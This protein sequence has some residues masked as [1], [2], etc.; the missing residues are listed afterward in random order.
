VDERFELS[1]PSR[2]TA[3]MV[4]GACVLLVLAGLAAVVR[5]G[6]LAVE[7]PTAPAGPGPGDPP[8]PGD[9]PDGPPDRPD[10]PDQPPVGL[11]VRR[12]LWA[13][14]LAVIAGIGAG[15]LAAGAGGRLVMRLLAVTAGDGAQGRITEADQVVGR[16]SAGGTVE[17]VVFT[18][19]FF[20]TATGAAYLLVRRWLPEGRAGGLVFGTLLL[21]VAGTRL[22][23]LREGNVDFDLVGPGWVSVLA[24][25]ALVLFHGML[26][27]AL[28]GRASRAVPLLRR[29]PV[30]VAAY[31]PLLLLAPLV[32]VVVVLT[33]VGGLVVLATRARPLVA[34]WHARRLD[35]AGQVVLALVALVALPGFVSAVASILGRS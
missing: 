10:P 4:I 20:G 33:V 7:P 11:V 27:A 12:Y 14:N 35:L 6:G 22:E 26:V 16:I 31:A 23:P 28:A 15:I 2:H 8:R 29:E 21:L 9:G 13:V 18:A 34:T 25:S 32:P 3:A 19:L 5:W 24:F 1:K 17:F 30:A